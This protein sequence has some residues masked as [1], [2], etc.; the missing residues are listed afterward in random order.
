MAAHFL[1]VGDRAGSRRADFDKRLVHL[2]DDLADHLF[3]I[4][5]PVEQVG[6]VGG[7]DVAGARKNT[8]LKNSCRNLETLVCSKQK[9]LVPGRGKGG[10]CPGTSAGQAKALTA[11]DMTAATSGPT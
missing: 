8:H 1:L 7:D 10:E 6:D 3:G 5:G 2:E 4:F 9:R 11:G